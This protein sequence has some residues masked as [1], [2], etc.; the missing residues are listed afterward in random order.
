VK[1]ESICKFYCRIVNLCIKW[2][3][4]EDDA[5]QQKAISAPIFSISML[6]YCIVAYLLAENDLLMGNFT[7]RECKMMRFDY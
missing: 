5:N 4:G 1:N 6:T 7:M 2:W 3:C